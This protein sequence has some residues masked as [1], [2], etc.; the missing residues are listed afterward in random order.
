MTDFLRRLP[1][2]AGQRTT[3]AASVSGLSVSDPSVGSFALSNPVPRHRARGGAGAEG[4]GEDEQGDRRRPTRGDAVGTLAA[5]AEERQMALTRRDRSGPPPYGQRKGFVPRTEEDFGGGGAFPEIL[6][7]QFPLGMG[8]KKGGNAAASTVALQLG[9]D[10]KIAYDVVVRQL[11][12]KKVVYSTPQ[13]ADGIDTLRPVATT[14]SGIQVV[15]RVA[16]AMPSQEEEDKEI[17]RTKAALEAALEQKLGANKVKT[18]QDK[19]GAEFYRYTPAQQGTGHNSGCAQRV[20]RVED[21]QEDPMNPPKFRHKRA[22]AAAGSPPPPVMHSPPR[23]LTQQDQAEWKIPPSISNWKNQ[24]GYTIP[25]DKRLQADGRNLQDVSIND[26]FASLSEALYIAERQAREEIR[27]RNEIK[28]QKKIK[29]EEMREQQLRLLAA[30]ARAERSNLLQQRTEGQEEDEEARKKREAVARERQREIER[31]M[32]LERNKRGR[33]DEDRDVSER[34]ALGLPPAKKAASGEGVF[35][36]RLFNQSAGVDS[37]FDGGNDEAYNLYDQPLFANRSNNAAI[38]QFSRERLIN[39]VG[40]TGDVPSFA[41]AD[42]STFTRTAPVEFEKDVSDPFGLD[43]L[44]S[45]AKK[46]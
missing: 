22:P 2:P 46:K 37:G 16:N 4:R 38:Y 10:G 14:A 11:S 31:E 17:A 36:T 34:V 1:A 12:D 32:R 6:V 18:K 21:M 41:G 24:K 33:N 15:K 13:T 26:K 19:S 23:K 28:K 42:R 8:K 9:G 20:L 35:D 27:L 29:E 7:A 44:L 40:H 25:L 39:S 43:N 5:L 45:E 3:Q 30:Q